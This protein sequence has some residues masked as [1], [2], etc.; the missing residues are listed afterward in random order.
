MF[1]IRCPIC[2]EAYSL[3]D[4][5]RGTRAEC[6]ICGALLA[7][8]T[9]DGEVAVLRAPPCAEFPCPSCQALHQVYAYMQGSTGTCAQCGSEFLIA[10][11]TPTCHET[12]VLPAPDGA[13]RP[14]N[15]R[16]G[17]RDSGSWKNTETMRLSFR[18]ENAGP[19]R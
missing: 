13:V 12:V 4:G 19:L 5:L 10:H 16:P 17:L 2:E 6:Q 18:R 3:N 14:A 7:L 1:T 8:P 9:A 15:D 11:V